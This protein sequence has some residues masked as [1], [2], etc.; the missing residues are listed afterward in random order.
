MKNEHKEAMVKQLKTLISDIEE[1]NV[2][3]IRLKNTLGLTEVSTRTGV[4]NMEIEYYDPMLE[5]RGPQ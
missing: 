4:I 3:V 5:S 1:G 2:T